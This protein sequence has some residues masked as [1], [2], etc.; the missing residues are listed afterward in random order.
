MKD[1]A[2]N[3]EE[4]A[5]QRD[6]ID[7]LFQLPPPAFVAARNTLAADLAKAGHEALAGRIKALPKPSISAWAVNQLYWRHRDSFDKLVATGERFRRAQGARLEGKGTDV[8]SLLNERRAVLSENARLAAAILQRSSGAAPAGVM[9]R[10]T[11][12]LEALAAYGRTPDAPRAGRLITDVDPPGFDALAALV[13]RVG[14]T[15]PA[16]A[17]SRVLAF[18]KG[19][20][21][22]RAAASKDP[23]QIARRHAEQLAAARAARDEAARALTA[24]RQAAQKA[25][26]SMKRAALGAQRSEKDVAAAEARLQ[27]IAARAHDDRQR[28]RRA[29]ADAESAT[30]AVED[31]ERRLDRAAQ[32]LAKLTGDVSTP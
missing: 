23:Q 1:G 16:G 14:D 25:Q 15:T 2:G 13:P 4:T 30:Q 29:A 6:Q 26:A 11:A 22:T 24:A 19:R 31:A 5:A 32:T 8:R 20:P 3:P 18:Q 7:A 10:I 9:R 12:T 27:A 17:P 28:A 21:T